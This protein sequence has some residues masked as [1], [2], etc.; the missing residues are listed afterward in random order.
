M[1]NDKTTKAQA[2]R[3][4]L[5]HLLG[6]GTWPPG[7]RI[8]SSRDLA[9]SRGLS[10]STVVSVLEELASEGWIETRAGSGTFAAS[11]PDA[12]AASPRT[13]SEEPG[14]GPLDPGRIDFRTGLPELASFP[15]ARWRRAQKMAENRY[16]PGLW[17]YG[18][19]EGFE[20]LRLQVARYLSRSRGWQARPEQLVIVGGT[21]QALGLVAR[22]LVHTGRTEAYV[23]DPVTVDIP[24]ILGLAGA[25]VHD[26]PLEADGPDLGRVPP[27][28]EG[29]F[30]MLTPSHQ[31]P[32][33]RITSAAKR[34]ELLRRAEGPALV[35]DDYD[36]EFRNP[37]GP[38]APLVALDP[39]K[40]IHLG[41]FS[42][43]L[44]PG[45]R[46]AWIH[47]PQVLVAEAR[48]L[49]WLSDLHNPLPIQACLSEFL[50]QGWYDLH[51]RKMARVYRR[52]RELVVAALAGSGRWLVEGEPSGLNLM[53]R[54]R[55]GMVDQD[56]LE[57]CLGAGI[58]V[59]PVARHVRS[60]PGYADAFLLGFGHLSPEDIRR[61]LSALNGPGV[62]G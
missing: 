38:L 27:S 55:R 16:G 7:S 34:R 45:L 31:F 50:A 46:I 11:R 25:R 9:L 8:S 37:G 48:S 57:A 19:A 44:A 43:T 21:T 52:K 41:T 18:E 62:P 4:E 15:L 30:V 14:L 36:S 1:K 51:V 20:G 29:A 61:G 23:E 5:I 40:V 49:K 59:Y 42:K 6:D 54:R 53:V 2:L 28:L 58:K 24:R 60:A 56:F 32:T 12:L 35:E 17:G 22:L 3:A 39:E 26:L 10:R 13:V 33:G 47:L